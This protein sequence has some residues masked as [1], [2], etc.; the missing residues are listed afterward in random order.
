[1][2]RPGPAA[3]H[4]GGVSPRCAADGS[5]CCRPYSKPDQTKQATRTATAIA[6]ITI[7][8]DQL[9][10]RIE[11]LDLMLFLPTP[12]NVYRRGY[13]PTATKSSNA[14]LLCFLLSPFACCG[15]ERLFYLLSA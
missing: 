10:D 11:F 14:A 3:L 5:A 9:G 1:M 13:D 4:G 7:Y 15:G 12:R 2:G 8:D 6:W